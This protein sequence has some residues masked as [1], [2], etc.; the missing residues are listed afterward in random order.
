MLRE[1]ATLC[2]ISISSFLTWRS[3][4]SP[5]VP[6]YQFDIIMNAIRLVYNTDEEY[7]R[8]VC[9][10]LYAQVPQWIQRRHRGVNTKFQPGLQQNNRNFNL[11]QLLRNQNQG[12]FRN[13]NFTGRAHESVVMQCSPVGFRGHTPLKVHPP[14]ATYHKLSHECA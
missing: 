1:L 7:R 2:Y 13:A 8:V 4:F 10:L 12:K 5:R 3:L 9:I 6:D 14:T 11:L